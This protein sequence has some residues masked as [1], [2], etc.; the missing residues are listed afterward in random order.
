[1][2]LNF[3]KLGEPLKIHMILFVSFMNVLNFVSSDRNI[4]HLFLLYLS[5]SLRSVLIWLRYFFCYFCH[6]MP[7][8]QYLMSSW[9]KIHF[10]PS[11]TFAMWSQILWYFHQWFLVISVQIQVLKFFR[12]FRMRF[13]AL[14]Y[15][16]YFHFRS[17]TPYKLCRWNIWRRLKIA[18]FNI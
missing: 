5:V 6:K 2:C 14:M 1:M 4:S 17:L 18:M 8:P 9:N 16:T 11:K 12:V 13:Y 15:K 10:V 7:F 3:C